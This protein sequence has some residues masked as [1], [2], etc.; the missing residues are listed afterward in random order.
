MSDDLATLADWLA[1]NRDDAASLLDV[2]AWV[3]QQRQ[4]KKHGF[5][6]DE[7][8][9]SDLQHLIQDPAFCSEMLAVAIDFELPPQ[10]INAISQRQPSIEEP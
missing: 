2:L 1:V 6:N 5:P 9:G 10:L 8:K 7:P 4:I 3:R